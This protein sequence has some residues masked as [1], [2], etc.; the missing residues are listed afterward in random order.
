[1]R[2]EF[3]HKSIVIPILQKKY[4]VVNDSKN[5]ELTFVVGGCKKNETLIDCAIRELREETR[6][7]LGKINRDDLMYMSYFES[8]N[9]STSEL[10]KDKK[11]GVF[12][13][14]VYNIFYLYLNDDT[15]FDEI[16]NRYHSTRTV[17]GETNN[18]KLMTKKQLEQSK[19]WRFM[20]QNVLIS[21]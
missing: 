11:E 2:H 6:G 14:M 1:M 15:D 21:L 17:D 7:S 13:T 12:V 16:Y 19:M 4:I 5:D 3:R 9:R 18:I 10:K 8:R 20:K